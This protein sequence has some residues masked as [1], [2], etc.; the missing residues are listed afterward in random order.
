MKTCE[1][2]FSFLNLALGGGSGRLPSPAALLLGKGPPISVEKEA[3]RPLEPIWALGKGKCYLLRL[4]GIPFGFIYSWI[5]LNLS[6]SI[7]LWDLITFFCLVCACDSRYFC[8]GDCEGSST[9]TSWAQLIRLCFGRLKLRVESY[10]PFRLQRGCSLGGHFTIRC[11]YTH[12]AAYTTS[13]M[14]CNSIRGM[15]WHWR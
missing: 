2:L 12:W 1:E 15:K 5:G 13:T 6:S 9:K 7:F 4:P 3:A 14:I 11:P 10:N 8:D